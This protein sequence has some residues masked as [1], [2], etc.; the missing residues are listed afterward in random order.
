M[1]S[2]GLDGDLKDLFGAAINNNDVLACGYA[3]DEF[4]KLCCCLSDGKDCN[5]SHKRKGVMVVYHTL[6]ILIES[7]VNTPHPDQKQ[8]FGS[9]AAEG[10]RKRTEAAATQA[11]QVW[12]AARDGE[13]VASPCDLP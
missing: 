10:G 9:E 2:V 6:E 1:L 12:S 11:E 13:I 7:R 8:L 3:L 5:V 4:R